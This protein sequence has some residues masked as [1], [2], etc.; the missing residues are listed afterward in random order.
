MRTP[1][2][3]VEH[4][5]ATLALLGCCGVAHA[6]HADDRFWV[7][8]AGYRPSIESSARS[9]FLANDITGTVVRFEDEL[10][11]ADRKTLP[12]FQAG[13]R[14]GERWRVELEYF[15]LRRSGERS[16]SREIV[17]GDTVFP[18]SATLRSQFDSDILRVS[19]GYS[20]LKD[21]RTEVGAVLGLHATRFRL[22]LEGAMTVEGE[23]DS[24]AGE[25]EEA[26]VPLPTLGLY[27]KRDFAPRWSVA[28][29]IDYF[30]LNTGDFGGGLLNGM[31]AF[32]YRFTD[33]FGLSAGYRYV[34]Y[35][36]D[37]DK[38]SW[39][40]GLDYRFSGPF[41]SLQLGF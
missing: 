8:L 16:G 18:V 3:T 9:D 31:I 28:G 32:G 35:T 34:D 5:A 19:A 25:A 29:R 22:A 4:A 21:E 39:R 41:V 30:T 24:G 23:S 6:Q 27:G 7:H 38:P 40:G 2:R 17:W 14:L 15:S 1:I 37:V 26:L 20:F 11:L 36:L 12:W 10:G 33:R 13:A